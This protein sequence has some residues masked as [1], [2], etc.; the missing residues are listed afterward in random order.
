MVN[1]IDVRHANRFTLDERSFE[2][3]EAEVDRIRTLCKFLE[4]PGKTL[5]VAGMDRSDREY[6]PIRQSFGCLILTGVQSQSSISAESVRRQFD[7][8]AVN[9]AAT[10][11]RLIEYALNELILLVR[12]LA[13][14]RSSLR[15]I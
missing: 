2:T 11:L 4:C 1:E 6:T 10:A 12:F 8:S 15:K 3:M 13:C 7:L 14:G 9:T 5:T